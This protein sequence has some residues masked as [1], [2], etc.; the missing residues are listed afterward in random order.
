MIFQKGDIL[1]SPPGS[2]CLKCRYDVCV[3]KGTYDAVGLG[4]DDPAGQTARYISNIT[5]M[6]VSGGLL[7]LVSCNWTKDELIQHFS[8]GLG[9]IL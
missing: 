7:I 1:E 8:K 2:E 5:Q 6:L 9:N 4:L 3:D